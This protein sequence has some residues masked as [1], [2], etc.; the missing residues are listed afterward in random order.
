MN[1]SLVILLVTHLVRDVMC[2]CTENSNTSCTQCVKQVGCHW[3]E[4]NNFCGKDQSYTPDCEGKWYSYSQCTIEG[5]GIWII[6][7]GVVS[8]AV[9]IICI[10]CCVRFRIS[11]RNA[12]KNREMQRIL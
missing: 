10:G 3:C 6:V 12:D 4:T 11:I 9:F 5:E 8:I 1:A 7:A 2:I